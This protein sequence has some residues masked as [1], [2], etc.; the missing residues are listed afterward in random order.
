MQTIS[1]QED[2]DT[3]ANPPR[4]VRVLLCTKHDYLTFAGECDC[5]DASAVRERYAV[6][7]TDY[8]W[9]HNSSGDIRFWSSA[10]GARRAAKSYRS[11]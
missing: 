11:L 5:R 9:L 3:R 4:P 7:G 8:G 10:S 2:I 6:A 1:R